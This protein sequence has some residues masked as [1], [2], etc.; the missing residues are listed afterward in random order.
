MNLAPIRA[1]ILGLTIASGGLV[2]DAAAQT[3][4][5]SQLQ[6][7]LDALDT[8]TDTLGPMRGNAEKRISLM[9]RF[10]SESNRTDAWKSWNGNAKQDKFNGMTFQQ[11]YQQALAQEKSRGMP[12]A[13]DQNRD[14]LTAEI[15]G[16]RTLAEDQWNSVNA[17]HEQVARMTAFLQS[18]KAMD[19]YAAFAQKAASDPPKRPEAGTDRQSE[20]GGITPA[21]REANIKKY[22]AQQEALQKHWD[23]YHFTTGYSSVPPGG[24]FRGNPQGGPTV[25]EDPNQVRGYNPYN[26]AYPYG[27]GYGGD[28][29]GG[30]WWNGYADPYYDVYGGRSGRFDADAARGA[31]VRHRNSAPRIHRR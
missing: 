7:E 5:M 27:G 3:D 24:P 22:R 18:E 23:N 20:Q 13:P 19:D 4:S 28:Y 9:K 30:S 17:L 8:V 1:A 26:G 11:A 12:K 29:W 25:G 16:Q 6:L 21:Q 10:I 31:Y 14:T 2:H 15:K